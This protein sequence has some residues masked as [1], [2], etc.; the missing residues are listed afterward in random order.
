MSTKKDA[1]PMYGKPWL[2]QGTF[3]TFQDADV[4]R[5]KILENSDNIQVKVRRS[6]GVD[7]FTVRTRPITI[8][9]KNGKNN[10]GGDTSPKKLR[11]EKK[12]KAREKRAKK[13]KA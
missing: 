12:R 9:K 8:L 13:N 10:G 1:G 2:I 5:K 11:Q 3:K 7:S 6:R 4:K